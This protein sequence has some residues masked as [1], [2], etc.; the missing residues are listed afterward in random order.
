[1]GLSLPVD[2][3]RGVFSCVFYTGSAALTS[4]LSFLISLAA[5]PSGTFILSLTSY[6]IAFFSKLSF[7]FFA[8][9]FVSSLVSPS[10]DLAGLAAA[11]TSLLAI[12][13][14]ESLSLSFSYSFAKAGSLT[15]SFSLVFLDDVGILKALSV[16][17]STLTVSSLTSC[18]ASTFGA[19]FSFLSFALVVSPYVSFDF[20]GF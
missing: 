17:S 15:S 1:L 20:L 12:L 16:K 3:F 5:F 2:T 18:L 10:A 13:S 8:N 7:T 6:S 4:S 14:I 11:T 19:A 9:S